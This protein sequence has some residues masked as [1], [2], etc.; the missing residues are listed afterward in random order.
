MFVE[1]VFPQE[2]H[3]SST[4]VPAAPVLGVNPSCGL[5]LCRGSGPCPHP[6]KCVLGLDLK[7]PFIDPSR[8]SA[9]WN[10]ALLTICDV[11]LRSLWS[12]GFILLRDD[13]LLRGFSLGR[14][15]P[16]TESQSAGFSSLRA[17]GSTGELWRT[18]SGLHPGSDD[19]PYVHAHAVGEVLARLPPAVVPDLHISV[20]GPNQQLHH[21]HVIVHGCDVQRRVAAVGA[22]INADG[23]VVLFGKV[24]DERQELGLAVLG[25]PVQAGEAGDEVLPQKEAGLLIE[26]GLQTAP[27]PIRSAHHPLVLQGSRVTKDPLHPGWRTPERPSRCHSWRTG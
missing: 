19:V 7:E 18:S 26:E 13:F 4:Q 12:L 21:L 3:D 24:N 15:S 14:P 8:S 17:S 9:L 11:L 10:E 16:S 25:R 6:K 20:V 27:L 5:W 1:S 2:L 22:D 23:D